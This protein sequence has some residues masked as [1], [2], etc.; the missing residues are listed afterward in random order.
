MIIIFKVDFPYETFLFHLHNLVNFICEHEASNFC[1]NKFE[2]KMSEAWYIWPRDKSIEK[3]LYMITK[4]QKIIWKKPNIKKIVILKKNG[5]QIPTA[6]FKWFFGYFTKHVD[7][8]E[9]W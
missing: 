6:L 5:K 2:Y 4:I 9:T 1:G 3:K 7:N 8:L